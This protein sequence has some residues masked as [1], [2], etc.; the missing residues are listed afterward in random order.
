MAGGPPLAIAPFQTLVTVG[1]RF[2]V[3]F[4]QSEPPRAAIDVR[5]C[6]GLLAGRGPGKV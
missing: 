5:L 3:R 1:A 6:T 2:N 4:R